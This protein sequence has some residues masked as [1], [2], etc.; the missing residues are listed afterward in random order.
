MYKISIHKLKMLDEDQLIYLLSECSDEELLQV[1]RSY[2][3]IK[4]YKNIISAINQIQKN[5]LYTLTKQ[6]SSS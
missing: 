2:A 6:L 5:K 4:G 1:K 3:D